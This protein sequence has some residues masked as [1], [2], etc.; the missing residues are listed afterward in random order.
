M[1]FWPIIGIH[2]EEEGINLL[3]KIINNFYSNCQDLPKPQPKQV[4]KSVYDNLFE[5]V[6]KK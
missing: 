5:W 4:K 2:N 6:S 3:L 1:N